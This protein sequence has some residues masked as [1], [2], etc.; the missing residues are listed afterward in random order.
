MTVRKLR[1]E[2]QRLEREGHGPKTAL[3]YEPKWAAYV[4]AESLKLSE[5]IQGIVI[6]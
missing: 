6:A 4:P 2:L 3:I 1:E 5:D